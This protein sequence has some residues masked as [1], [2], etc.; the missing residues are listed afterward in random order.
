[1]KWNVAVEHLCFVLTGCGMGVYDELPF[2]SVC[3]CVCVCPNAYSIAGVS[4]EIFSS[5]I[6]YGPMYYQKLK[7]MV[8]DKMH[9]RARLETVF[10]CCDL[11]LPVAVSTSLVSLSLSICR[12]CCLPTDFF[13][14][15]FNSWVEVQEQC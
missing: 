2:V 4:G 10:A 6:F 1:M 15:W 9:A 7:H 12:V 5:Y 11:S 13:I 8:L 14:G 3:V